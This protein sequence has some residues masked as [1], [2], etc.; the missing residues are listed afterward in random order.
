MSVEILEKYKQLKNEMYKQQNLI[1]EFLKDTTK[2]LEDRWET[3]LKIEDTL[4]INSYYQNIPDMDGR[5][6]TYY[7][8]LYCDKYQTIMFSDIIERLEP[9]F[10]KQSI[11]SLKELLLKTG[12]GGCINDW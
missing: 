1:L 12:N 10:S 7:D 8:D 5:E 6:V 4:P 3:Y 11:D 9:D 2:P